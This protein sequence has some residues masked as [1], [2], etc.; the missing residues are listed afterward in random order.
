MNP[1]YL[2]FR[3]KVTNVVGATFFLFSMMNTTAYSEEKIISCEIMGGLGNQLFQ[4]A[5]TLATAWDYGYDPI[6]PALD[7]SPSHIAPRPVYWDTVFKELKTL[8]EHIFD[9]YKKYI[10]IEERAGIPIALEESHVK[11]AGYWQSEKHFSA[12]R[13][14]L[15]TL[16]QLPDSLATYVDERFCSLTKDHKGP[17]VSVHLRLGDYL[18][19]NGFMCLWKDEFKHYYARAISCFPED[20]LFVVFSD[21][22]PYAQEFFAKNFSQQKVVF[23]QEQDYIELYLMAKCDHNI[24]ANSTFSWWGAYLN[25]NPEKIVISPKEWT[26]TGGKGV[27][28]PN[29]LPESWITIS[30]LDSITPTR[31][32]VVDLTLPRKTPSVPTL[33]IEESTDSYT[34]VE[35]NPTA[36]NFRPLDSLDC[37]INP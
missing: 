29:Y 2:Y 5:T 8:P 14:Q 9:D 21:D 19:L 18:T 4:I 26:V 13:N 6:F 20:T 15:L 16:F 28:Y 3:K 24:I 37:I 34:W 22:I 17:T 36:E 30:V 7:S 27:Y 12:Y 31:N 10:E 25:E 35:V 1:I 32:F 11:L 23:P 33:L